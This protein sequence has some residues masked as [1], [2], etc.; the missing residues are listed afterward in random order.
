[1]AVI[2]GGKVIEGAQGR[3]GVLSAEATA[4]DPA[5]Y[6]ALRAVRVDYSF[7]VDG[8]AVG[9][10]ALAGS[11]VIPAGA[12]VLGG[13]LEVTTPPTSGGAATIAVQVEAA[14]DTV[15][16]AAI[17][18]APWSTAG[19]KSVIPVFTGAT[20]LKTTAAR[21]VS[22]VVATAALTAGAFSVYLFYVATA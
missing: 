10:I 17:S 20:S 11:T 1:M 21:D 14:G 2:S 6:G 19:R 9:T 18:G 3:A 22:I 4:G 5:A 7:A 16:A 15:A 12:I 13:L 8:G